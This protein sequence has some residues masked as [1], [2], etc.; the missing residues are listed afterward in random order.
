MGSEMCIRDRILG[1]LRGE[2]LSQ[3][4]IIDHFS[5]NGQENSPLCGVPLVA[6]FRQK[7]SGRH[8]PGLQD[9]QVRSL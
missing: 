7:E 1:L 9:L 6:T 3:I 8:G 2:D 4:L 5:C